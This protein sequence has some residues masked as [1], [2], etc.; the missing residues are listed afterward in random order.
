MDTWNIINSYDSNG[1]TEKCKF[2]GKKYWLKVHRLNIRLK[3]KF[4]IPL[5]T[6]TSDML[7]RQQ[8]NILDLL[9]ACDLRYYISY[10]LSQYKILTISRNFCKFHHNIEIIASYLPLCY[11][12]VLP[13]WR[14]WGSVM[15]SKIGPPTRYSFDNISNNIP[16]VNSLP[17]FIPNLNFKFKIPNKHDSPNRY[18]GILITLILTWNSNTSLS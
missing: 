2:K 10:F 5:F 14:R 13:N 17:I 3:H 8:C 9:F 15:V 12:Q 4:Q 18:Q 16:Y 1:L 11:L 6:Y 7:Y